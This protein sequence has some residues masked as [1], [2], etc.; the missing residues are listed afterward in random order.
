MKMQ[1]GICVKKNNSRSIFLLEDGRF[2]EGK[3]VNATEVG[4]EGYFE[5]ASRG[6]AMHWAKLVAP[7]VALAAV[8]MLL[9]STM[10]PSEEAYAYI[11]LEANPGIELGIDEDIEVISVRHLNNDGKRMIE[12][13]GDWEG[14]SLD[15][16][17]ARSIDL[18]AGS[19]TEEVTITTVP[20]EVAGAEK[21]PVEQA[22]LAVAVA[23]VKKNVD[24][25][26]KKATHQQWKKS[27]QENVPVGQKVQNFTPVA[28]EENTG[29]LKTKGFGAPTGH[30]HPEDSKPAVPPGQQKKADA[31]VK[32]DKKTVPPGQQKKSD[33]SVNANP[34]NPPKQEKKADP[35]KQ[36]Q[37][38]NPPAAGKKVQT[39]AKAAPQAAEPKA[40]KAA[41][42]VKTEAE[43][44]K[45]KAEKTAPPV[46]EKKVQP[47][48]KEKKVKP[49]ETK[50][51]T[52]VQG[53]TK[54]R[55]TPEQKKKLNDSQKKN[56][57]SKKGQK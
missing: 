57:N 30:V 19:T 26:L 50:K 49:P 5:P 18:A 10:M 35:P 29:T 24:I 16:I 47:P 12:K 22:V 53:T 8:L 1:K 44:T 31:E 52:P 38:A 13:L 14:E 11:Q 4:E 40:K 25:H 28:V 41:P 33:G 37:K 39:P 15:E 48:K 36:E 3:P 34:V 7:A 17:L 56:S 2:L 20:G 51:K 42:K 46:K 54:N 6:F 21:L 55:K 45:P 43:K 27:I 23:A 32:K 9:F